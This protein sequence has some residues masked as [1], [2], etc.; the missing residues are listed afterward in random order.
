MMIFTKIKKELKSKEFWAAVAIAIP[1]GLGF[2]FQKEN[3]L[4]ALLLLLPYGILVM[5][6]LPLAAAVSWSV[7]I[8]VL[9]ARLHKKLYQIHSKMFK[10]TNNVTYTIK[11]EFEKETSQK[12]F[13]FFN[14]WYCIGT[15]LLIL[16]QIGINRMQRP[17]S[18]IVMMVPLIMLSIIFISAVN[19]SVYLMKKR[20]IMFESSDGT[21]VNLG[22]QLGDVIN[23]SISATQ[24]IS[25]AYVIVQSTA[26]NA[27]VATLIL[28]LVIC[29]GSSWFSF[30]I[31]RRKQM[32]KLMDKFAKKL[33][34]HHII[35]N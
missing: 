33:Q 22:S 32:P 18:I 10:T 16:Q 8:A 27:F 19:V 28:S 1:A 7:N 6:T 24:V 14:T 21:R 20:A 12:N 30:F 4:L 3:P 2:Y 31:L 5:I 17:D 29:I 34:E 26:V 25:F 13:V 9:F 35:S 15:T 23:S 11:K